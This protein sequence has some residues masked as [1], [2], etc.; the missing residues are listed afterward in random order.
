MAF[1]SWQL[2]LLV[3]LCFLPLVPAHARLPE[4][5][6]RRLRP[7]PRAGRRPARRRVRVGGR[8]L[9]GPGLRRSRSAPAG[10]ST[11]PSSATARPPARAQ[12]LVGAHLLHRRGGRRP[13]QRRR[14]SWSGSCSA[15]TATSPSGELLAFLFLVTLFVGPVQIGTEVLNEAQNAIAGWR[16]VL[17][18]LDT[19]ADVADP[20]EAGRMLPRGPIDVR[21]EDVSFAYPGGPTVLR[22]R[23]P[24]A[25]R[26]GPGSRWWAR[27]GRAR[28]RSPSC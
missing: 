22:G 2:T 3:W 12:A 19:P 23:R 18:V 16:R 15:S 1:Y 10:A 13:R 14:S 4:A 5:G 9:D 21:F 28:P 17:G 6:V 20:G 24:R 27:P 25:S 8:R 7:G 11:V 26:R